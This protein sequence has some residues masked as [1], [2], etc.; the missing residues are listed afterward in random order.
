[1]SDDQKKT[2]KFQ[3]MMSPAEAEGLDDWG[4]KRRIR[5]RAEVIRRLCQVGLSNIEK[6]PEILRVIMTNDSKMREMFVAQRNAIKNASP[7]E[8]LDSLYKV[9]ATYLENNILLMHEMLEAVVLSAFVSTGGGD[10]EEA[11][12]FQKLLKSTLSKSDKKSE[13][14]HDL[15]VKLIALLSDDSAKKADIHDLLK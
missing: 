3:M 11:I 12:D 6:L 10:I 4:F 5:S 13:E 14:Y 9:E 2:I 15:L 7:E 1:M 8:L